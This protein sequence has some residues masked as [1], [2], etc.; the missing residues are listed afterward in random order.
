M[1]THSGRKEEK[2]MFGRIL[3]RRKSIG[4]LIFDFFNYTFITLL[5][6][7]ILFPLWDMLVLSFSSPVDS[8]NLTMRLWPREWRLDAYIYNLSSE[9]TLNALY[10]SVFRTVTGTIISLFM[11]IIAAYPLSKRNLPFRNIITGYFLVP[12][13]FSG[14]LIPSYLINKSLG[15]VDNLLIYIIP[16][17]V[18]IFNVL[19]VRNYFMSI[20]QGL[21]ESAFIDGASYIT[22]LYKII[23]PVSKPIL[24]TIVLWSMVGQWNAW[25]DCLVY[26]RDEKKIVLQLLLRRMM[27]MNQQTSQDQLQFMMVDPTKVITTKTVQAAATIITITPIVLTY[28]FLQKYF[29]K[30]IMLGSLKG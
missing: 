15:L 17:A 1:N 23:I 12:M 30:G 13:F 2:N 28:P 7:S 21:E 14:G 27:D 19:L 16:G 11:V 22:I 25:F 9:K 5:C 8:S 6:I 10:V 24:A 18:G 20:D 26:I 29:V 4:D 3:L